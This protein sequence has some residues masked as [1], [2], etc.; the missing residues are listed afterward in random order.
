[1]DEYSDASSV[2]V[3][4]K[5]KDTRCNRFSVRYSSYHFSLDKIF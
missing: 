5:S 1:M 4:E 3:V 2:A